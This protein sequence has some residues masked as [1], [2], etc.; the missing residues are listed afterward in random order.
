LRK[1]TR[2]NVTVNGKL[3]AAIMNA[4]YNTSKRNVPINRFI[5]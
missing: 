4:V 2:K 3:K 5:G 1:L